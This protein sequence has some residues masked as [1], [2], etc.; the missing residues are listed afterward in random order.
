MLDYSTE[1][2][3]LL[4]ITPDSASEVCTDIVISPDAIIENEEEFTVVIDSSDAA[5]SIS[6]PD[7]SRTVHIIDS[8]SK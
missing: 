1:V 7:R 8:T 5:V 3:N 4:M 2:M 6:A